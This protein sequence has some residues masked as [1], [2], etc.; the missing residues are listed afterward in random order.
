MVSKLDQARKAIG[1]FMGKSVIANLDRKKSE[2]LLNHEPG[3]FLLRFADP[4]ELRSFL[5]NE[6]GDYVHGW[7]FD[8]SVP[9]AAVSSSASS[10]GH[11]FAWVCLDWS[12]GGDTPR[13]LVTTSDRWKI[14]DR[15]TVPSLADLGLAIT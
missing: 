5:E 7:N 2:G 13:V 6:Y 3:T 11:E 1:Q 9:V 8:V 14:H 10:E 15:Y 12:Q 4:S